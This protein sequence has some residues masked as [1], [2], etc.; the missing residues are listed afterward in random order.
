MTETEFL[1]EMAKLAAAFPH[2]APTELTWEV[3]W[4]NL[5]FVPAEKLIKGL[6]AAT[7]TGKFFPS[8]SEVLETSIGRDFAAVDYNPRRQATIVDIIRHYRAEYEI[9][10]AMIEARGPRLIDGKGE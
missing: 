9:Q 1:K 3:Y 7:Q 2:F 6:R 5:R 10:R 8:V 4:E